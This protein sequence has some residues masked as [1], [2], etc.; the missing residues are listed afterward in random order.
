MKL[1]LEQTQLMKI[2]SAVMKEPRRVKSVLLSKAE[3]HELYSTPRSC[4]HAEYGKSV[5]VRDA[6]GSSRME[7]GRSYRGYVHIDVLGRDIEVHAEEQYQQ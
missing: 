1:I 3:R 6:S 7:R 4:S 2:V 5:F